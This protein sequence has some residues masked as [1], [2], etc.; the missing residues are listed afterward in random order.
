MQIPA[1]GSRPATWWGSFVSESLS[2]RGEN[3]EKLFLSRANIVLH[4]NVESFTM[5]SYSSEAMKE[6]M[7]IVF[8]LNREWMLRCMTEKFK[9]TREEAQAS[10]TFGGKFLLEVFPKEIEKDFVLLK[11]HRSNI[12][13]AL[14]TLLQRSKDFA[15][16]GKN[17]NKA[18][19]AES[20]LFAIE[21]LQRLGSKIHKVEDYSK[22][23]PFSLTS[24]I[25]CNLCPSHTSP[26]VP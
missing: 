19:A 7:G 11:I 24:L 6:N 4:L 25:H 13:S 8:L 2:L 5:R 9:S 14:G 21:C 17:V 16:L 22:K 26:C 1:V 10:R 15:C 3:G 12:R 23:L 18:M 20:M